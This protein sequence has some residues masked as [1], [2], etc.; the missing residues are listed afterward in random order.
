MAVERFAMRGAQGLKKKQEIPLSWLFLTPVLLWSTVF[1]LSKI[2]LEVIPPTSLAAI[3]FSIGGGVMLLYVAYA[4]SWREAL[5]SL[6][7]SWKDFVLLGFIGIFAN[8]LL[9]N[10]G[11]SLTSASSASLLGTVDPVFTAILSAIFLGEP[12]TRSKLSGLMVA[13]VGVLIVT[14]NGQWVGDWGESLGNILVVGAAMGYSAYTVLSKKVLHREQPP[15]V[16]AWAT[17]IGALFLIVAAL[18][19]DAGRPYGALNIGHIATLAYLSIAPTSVAVVAYFYLLQRIQASQASVIIFLI[20]VLAV[21]WA[22]VLLGE[23]LT[24]AMLLGG[25]LIIWGV[26]MTMRQA[27]FSLP[28]LKDAQRQKDD[29]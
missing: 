25:S 5:L 13:F 19:I 9:Q 6:R 11:L 16:V 22:V 26:W 24:W 20:P 10:L 23:G 1:P 2:L 4:F 27:S 12:L 21:F 29:S 15:M 17:T 18:L 7:R 14:T 3:R 28:T 8:N